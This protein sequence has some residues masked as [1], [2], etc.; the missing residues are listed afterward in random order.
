[1]QWTLYKQ[2]VFLQYG[3]ICRS[4]DEYSYSTESDISLAHYNVIDVMSIL[5]SKHNVGNIRYGDVSV[6]HLDDDN[7]NSNGDSQQTLGLH[8]DEVIFNHFEHIDIRVPDELTGLR[9]FEVH[10]VIIDSDEGFKEAFIVCI[11]F[12]PVG[13][14]YSAIFFPIHW[15]YSIQRSRVR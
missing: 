13:L 5:Q 4:G 15:Q 3:D 9:G 12:V 8:M 10:L 1:M 14:P 7:F 2:N 6:D 11:L